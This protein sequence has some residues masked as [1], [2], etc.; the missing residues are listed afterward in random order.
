MRDDAR[1]DLSPEPDPAP[2]R[3][4]P[5]G[6]PSPSHR[7]SRALPF[8]PSRARVSGVSS[9]VRSSFVRRSF[10]R[11]FVRSFRVASR[12]FRR[13]FSPRGA[14]SRRGS[15]VR[16]D[17]RVTNRRCVPRVAVLVVVLVRSFVEDASLVDAIDRSFDRSTEAEDARR[18][19]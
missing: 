10:V 19:R 2:R 17:S 6:R 12:R 11:S 14:A 16:C 1:D 8:P 4:P 15:P 18:R 7:H 5:P 9:V 3:L 13:L